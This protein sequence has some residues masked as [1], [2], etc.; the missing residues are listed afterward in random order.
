[1]TLILSTQTNGTVTTLNNTNFVY[2][3]S[4][5]RWDKLV[6]TSSTVLSAVITC[7]YNDYPNSYKLPNWIQATITWS[8]PVTYTTTTGVIVFNY[9]TSVV[10]NTL[11]LTVQPNANTWQFYFK[12]E[13][14]L[15][16]FN[17]PVGAIKSNDAKASIK[18][19]IY[20]PIING[21]RQPYAEVVPYTGG[22]TYN[23]YV[24]YVIDTYFNGV[25]RYFFFNTPYSSSR[26]LNW[27]T[28]FKSFA[29]TVP[30]GSNTGNYDGSADVTQIVLVPVG[31]AA[32]GVN[33]TEY[34]NY[35]RS[36]AAVNSSNPRFNYF[37]HADTG[38][39]RISYSVVAAG[40]Y[41]DD[42][43]G[44]NIAGSKTWVGA[45][46]SANKANI[47]ASSPIALSQQNVSSITVRFDHFCA[48]FSSI[49]STST[50][51]VS[52]G[53]VYNIRVDTSYE[54]GNQLIMDY[55]TANVTYS[56][57]EFLVFPT[58]WA[59]FRIGDSSVSGY[60]YE[61]LSGSILGFTSSHGTNS[62]SMPGFFVDK[63]TPVITTT[64]ANGSTGFGAGSITISINKSVSSQAGKTYSITTS[65]GVF[66]TSTLL[67]TI[68]NTTTSSITLVGLTTATTYTLS[69]QDRAYSDNY[70]NASTATT[71]TFVTS[72]TGPVISTI[73]VNGATGVGD[74]TIQL[75]FER[76]VN[77]VIG[78]FYQITTSGGVFVTS[79]QVP[80]VTAGTVSSIILPS[81][82]T[83]NTAYTLS[84]DQ[85][86]YLDGAGF[87]TA[88]KS[89]TF[90]TTSSSP[91]GQAILLTSQNWTVPLF[92]SSIS[93]LAV[94]K[95]ADGLAAPNYY[96]SGAGG[97]GGTLAWKNNIPVNANDV[98][99][100]TMGTTTRLG[101]VTTAGYYINVVTGGATPNNVC[102]YGIG[103]AG[104][105]YGYYNTP[106]YYPGS[107]G[108]GGAGGYGGAGGNGGVGG[109]TLGAGNRGNA[110]SS[111]SG[112]G[113]N[114]GLTNYGWGG[115]GGG[116]GIYGQGSNGA[117]TTTGGV[118]GSGSG[119]GGGGGS[120][121]ANGGGGGAYGNG[122]GGYG[123]GGGGG[124]YFCCDGSWTVGPPGSGGPAVIRIVYGA[125]RSFPSTNVSSATA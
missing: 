13:G 124:N 37:I 39:N 33:T 2:N 59:Y 83:T 42:V 53:K 89:I 81:T 62:Y 101:T 21:T 91:A 36:V 54:S 92:V 14:V 31:G 122:G 117:Q 22:T 64:P 43:Y 73:P 28:T 16:Q 74:G 109:T 52:Y 67:P 99:V 46:P 55:V 86:A 38:V 18:N 102:G 40:A 95:G 82:A 41:R 111:G 1:M 107:A 30:T 57:T 106:N 75:L 94:S 96:T 114:G 4:A 56:Y 79:T 35:Q 120:S 15:G 76:P 85:G 65:G 47:V 29:S 108:G 48:L 87:A 61:I 12:F 112:A 69:I 90:V 32:Y 77:S 100:A 110:G 20:S 113:G 119:S 118:D 9:G 105:S 3:A 24:Y 80:T 5:T 103:G 25:P 93:V 116:V 26:Y 104:G 63:A 66:V 49:P 88:A 50:I 8:H 23:F 19:T 71:V 27:C 98:L 44:Y 10:T 51:S 121:G 78:K 60:A 70:S 6:S 45:F 11:S 34:S 17:I 58:D 7:S 68:S 125:N 123:G 115:G 97:Y 72:S 84:I